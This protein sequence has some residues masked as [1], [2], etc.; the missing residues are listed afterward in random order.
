MK[1]SVVMIRKMGDFEVHQR[2]KDGMFNAT[3]LLKQFNK[4]ERGRE[5]SEFL[6]NKKTIDFIKAIEEAENLN[7][8]KVVLITRGKNGGTLMHPYLFID[9]AMWIDPKFKVKVIRFVYDQLIKERHNAGDN[10]KRLSESGVKLNNYS[11]PQVATAM[12]WIVF[13]EKG[14]GQRQ[15]ATQ[16]QLIELNRIQVELSFAIDMGYIETF[17]GLMAEMRKMWKMKKNQTPF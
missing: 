9:F 12:N 11:F 6:G 17:D 2:T 13:G 8:E 7:T 1:T 10:Y 3:T 16:E 14:K 5:V 15:I 4:G